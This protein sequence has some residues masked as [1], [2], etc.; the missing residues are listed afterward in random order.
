VRHIPQAALRRAFAIFLL[1]VGAF[2]LWDKGRKLAARGAA[3]AAEA[4]PSR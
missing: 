1:V 3:P 4:S 2:M